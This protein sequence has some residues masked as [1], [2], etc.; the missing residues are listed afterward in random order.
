MNSH[1]RRVA[2]GTASI[3]IWMTKCEVCFGG[4]AVP[5]SLP[6]KELDLFGTKGYPYPLPKGFVPRNLMAL[7]QEF[8]CGFDGT[9]ALVVGL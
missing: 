6:Q 9:R 8:R 2:P 4:E 5:H 1:F 3:R 7:K